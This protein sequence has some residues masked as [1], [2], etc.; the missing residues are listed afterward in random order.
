MSNAS[1]QQGST[2]AE[3]AILLT[4]VAGVSIY[5]IQSLGSA[6]SGNLKKV[7]SMGTMSLLAPLGK[8]GSASSAAEGGGQPDSNAPAAVTSPS[9]L[10][11]PPTT[12]GI[13][14]G[15]PTTIVAGTVGNG[16]VVSDDRPRPPTTPSSPNNANPGKLNVPVSTADFRETQIADDSD[17]GEVPPQ[18][19]GQGGS[20]ADPAPG[21]QPPEG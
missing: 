5:G 19:A 21:G 6:M 9:L 13:I 11:D 2:I 3:Y 17:F 12:I 10:T 8:A 16:Q 14:D 7:D 20:F 18:E 1:A 4:L 15:Q